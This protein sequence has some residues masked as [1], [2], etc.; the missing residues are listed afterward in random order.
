[1]TAMAT[2]ASAATAVEEDRSGDL[3]AKVC[4]EV[5]AATR[6]ANDCAYERE[7]PPPVG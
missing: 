3:V 6:A 1:M 2:A 7:K 5:C 4:A